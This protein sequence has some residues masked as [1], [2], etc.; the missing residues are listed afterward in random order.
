M[1]E[2]IK[3]SARLRINKLKSLP[4]LPE[5]S[6]KIL[7][8][9]NDPDISIEK[10]TEVLALSPGLVARLLGLANSA[11]FGQTRQIKDL[12]TA[13]VQ[14]LGLQLVKSLTVGIVLNVQIDTRQCKCFDTNSFWMHSLLT[15]VAAQKLVA[16]SERHHPVTGSV[17]YTGGLLLH[18]GLLVI[19]YL[20]PK[21]FDQ[22]LAAKQKDY[23]ELS[24]EVSLH[25]GLS[26]YQMGYMLLNKWQLPDVYQM[27]LRRFEDANLT[28]NEAE[29][30][31][32]LRV[33][34]QICCMLLDMGDEDDG[35]LAQI[36]EQHLFSVDAI[37]RVFGELVG[38]KD[39]IQKLAD[40]M[41]HG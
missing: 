4:A 12:R 1:R 7:E 9:I 31:N 24:H 38:K 25:L 16:I 23:L 21:E 11:Y 18:I 28:G 19:A 14:V 32:I 30:I 8:A 5:A 29:Q 10:L 26:Q 20:F 2:D 13:I 22:V 6:V 36:A 34:Q 33:S 15:A 40:V 39:N 37:T 17:V 41:G 35:R 3:G 27:I